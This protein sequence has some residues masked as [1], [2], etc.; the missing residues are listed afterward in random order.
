MKYLCDGLGEGWPPSPC[1]EVFAL[2]NGLQFYTLYTV[3][4]RKIR[5]ED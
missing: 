1:R 2:G 5:P 4:M 3:Q